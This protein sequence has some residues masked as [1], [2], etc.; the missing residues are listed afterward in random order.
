VSN[1][2]LDIK[3]L[4]QDMEKVS[5]FMARVGYCIEWQDTLEKRILELKSS[6]VSTLMVSSMLASKDISLEEYLLAQTM[7]ERSVRKGRETEKSGSTP[8]D[9]GLKRQREEEMQQ[10]AEGA[11]RKRAGQPSGEICRNFQSGRC[12]RGSECKF[13]H[14]ELAFRQDNRN[15][16][17]NQGNPVRRNIPCRDWLQ[18]SCLW[19]SCKYE[20]SQD[21]KTSNLTK[22]NEN[23]EAG[24]PAEASNSGEKT[25]E[26]RGKGSSKPVC[27]KWQKFGTCSFGGVCRFEHGNEIITNKGPAVHE[28]RKGNVPGNG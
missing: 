10:E 22:H 28:S 13:R 8:A 4:R 20:H 12:F 15:S 7:A 14:I 5:A 26:G 3:E 21:L 6:E 17:F 24:K 23:K 25:E 18:G 11:K 1:P 19:T 16:T 9:V 2:D 27:Y